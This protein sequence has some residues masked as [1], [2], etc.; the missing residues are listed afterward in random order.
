MDPKNN[1][2]V[3][4][5]LVLT[6]PLEINVCSILQVSYPCVGSL[7]LCLMLMIDIVH[8]A[9]GLLVQDWL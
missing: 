4:D 2:G 8:L 5:P 7:I 1:S 6:Y 9:T 3:K